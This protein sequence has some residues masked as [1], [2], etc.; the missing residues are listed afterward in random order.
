[1]RK[2]VDKDGNDAGFLTLP[3]RMLEEA[4]G[5]G[6]IIHF[7]SKVISL[8]TTSQNTIV[9]QLAGGRLVEAKYV[10]LNIP[11]GP[12]IEMLRNSGPPFRTSFPEPL[13]N[14]VSFDVMKLYVHYEDAWWRNDLGLE[15]GH[16]GNK[17]HQNMELRSMVKWHCCRTQ[18]LFLVATTMVMCVATFQEGVVEVSCRLSS[19]L[20]A[21]LSTICLSIVSVVEMLQ[22]SRSQTPPRSTSTCLRASMLLLWLYTARHLLPTMLLRRLPGCCLTLVSWLYGER[23]SMASTLAAIL[24][25]LGVILR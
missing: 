1:M 20:A 10:L 13:Y 25:R 6:A 23:V 22:L 5:K 7:Q 15:S 24:P 8:A 3:E 16:F 18:L 12:I 19:L 11:Q 14:P 9:L 2:I 4:M 17:N 21:L